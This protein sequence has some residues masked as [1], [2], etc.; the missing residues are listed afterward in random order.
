MF[1]PDDEDEVAAVVDHWNK[2]QPFRWIF[3]GVSTPNVKEVFET[4]DGKQY[5][6]KKDPS[7]VEHSLVQT[8]FA[9]TPETLNNTLFK[10]QTR[11]DNF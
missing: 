9:I 8:K 1:Y 7:V 3:I 2:T 4:V 11:V 5:L 6:I 10:L